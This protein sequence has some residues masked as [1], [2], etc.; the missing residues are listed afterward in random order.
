MESFDQNQAA[1]LEILNVLKDI[2]G[3]LGG[4]EERLKNVENRLHS[5]A[6]DIPSTQ[7]D[8]SP[9]LEVEPTIEHF[10][11][12]HHNFTLLN[13]PFHST[14]IQ[15]R[16]KELL[17]ALQEEFRHYPGAP[18]NGSTSIISEPFVPLIHK[19]DKLVDRAKLGEAYLLE[20]VEFIES[21]PAMKDYFTAR[22]ANI[23]EGACCFDDLWTFYAPG[24]LVWAEVQNNDQIFEVDSCSPLYS[25]SSLDIICSMV[26]F[27][28]HEFVRTSYC[29]QV[30]RYTGQKSLRDLP[31]ILLDYHSDR[32]TFLA[33]MTSRGLKFKELCLA[34]PGSKTMREYEGSCYVESE[35]QEKL[36]DVKGRIVI[37]QLSYLRA[38][39]GLHYL[40]GLTPVTITERCVCEDCDEIDLDGKESSTLITLFPA[41]IFGFALRSKLWAQFSLE[42]MRHPEFYD[43]SL[44]RLTL[45]N[46]SKQELTALISAH[47]DLHKQ[48]L[49]HALDLIH[50]APM[51]TFIAFQGPPG[52]GKTL[53][54]EVLAE[55]YR[56]PLMDVSVYDKNFEASTS[57]AKHSILSLAQRWQALLIVMDANVLLDTASGPSNLSHGALISTV[58][59]AIECYRG[60][61]IFNTSQINPLQK[62][63]ADRIQLVLKFNELSEAD[64]LKIF[65]VFLGQTTLDDEERSLVLEYIKSISTGQRLSGRQIRNVVQVAISACQAESR[66]LQPAD[67]IRAFA[68]ASNLEYELN[69]I[70][71]DDIYTHGSGPP[72][73]ALDLQLSTWPVPIWSLPADERIS[74]SFSVG[75]LSAMASM[76]AIETVAQLKDLL[77]GTGNFQFQV[78]D[79]GWPR[80]IWHP[81][82][83]INYEMHPYSYE[84][85]SKEAKL[86]WGDRNWT[87][88]PRRR[89]LSQGMGKP[90]QRL[91]LCQQVAIP[92]EEI[93][94]LV[95]CFQDLFLLALW[96]MQA[97][98]RSL[99]QNHIILHRNSFTR[100]Q[101]SMN[102]QYLRREIGFHF[103]YFDTFFRHKSRTTWP[104]GEFY[105][106]PH[107]KFVKCSF[108]MLIIPEDGNKVDT[109]AWTMLCMTDDGFWDRESYATLKSPSLKCQ[110]IHF[111]ALALRSAADSWR[112]LLGEL[113]RTV[114]D[115]NAY[116]SPIELQNSFFVED[117]SYSNSRK[118]FWAIRVITEFIKAL[119][120]SIDQWRFYREARVEPFLEP[121]A[122]HF[123]D[124]ENL[125]RAWYSVAAADKEASAACLELVG[126][127][128]NLEAR[129]EEIKVMRDGL[130]NASAVIE[131]RAS[132]RLGENVKLLTYMTI[133][134]LPLAY[135][136]SVWSINEAYGR[137]RLA[138]VSILVAFGTY[139]VTF[140][141]GGLVKVLRSA[142]SLIYIPF[143]KKV[144]RGMIEDDEW[145][146]I[147]K[148]FQTFRLNRQ[149]QTPTEWY[150]PWFALV[151]V[152]RSVW[153]LLSWKK[154]AEKNKE[155]DMA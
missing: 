78:L 128:H 145:H 139:F 137:A 116:L 80:G 88:G 7:N 75:N 36:I 37:D 5:E 100:N 98:F 66:N 124:V 31:I 131:S 79:W 136:T 96:D 39:P 149:D 47:L 42:R 81:Q 93:P 113:E 129:L 17:Q 114:S 33:R 118:Y 30:P 76:S 58:L 151:Q 44:D 6:K 46:Q 111:I 68:V 28:G 132:T 61:I 153:N 123:V 130:F 94:N 21:L 89:S 83:G 67:I 87:F 54:T 63:L 69:L 52:V 146:G 135:C 49:D 120:D 24:S 144:E 60:L 51:G 134:F 18:F 154:K 2:R 90:W 53:M 105:E 8:T 142:V 82:R 119:N 73:P 112:R 127:K 92:Q 45:N 56:I 126:V 125:G 43:G 110:S 35:G 86:E 85:I 65:D 122:E 155:K 109:D 62:P 72:D 147:G 97:P 9:S 26:D 108:T 91:L 140:N 57:D 16:S 101:F 102:N 106:N 133:L 23:K 121:K 13:Y 38:Q 99:V 40:R 15:I 143:K 14:E 10:G 141:L 117:D 138:W 77:S 34:N 107:T 12:T 71:S 50:S 59:R 150:I 103:T 48:H 148:A 20:L 19:W 4:Q 95:G 64:S 25:R 27:D 104:V 3:Q 29:F 11:F 1:L 32:E 84:N 115:G 22:Q 55:Y 152:M 70:E 74:L 41:R